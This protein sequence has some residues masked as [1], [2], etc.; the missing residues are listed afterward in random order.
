MDNFKIKSYSKKELALLFFP[1]ST[2][3]TAVNHLMGIIRRCDPLWD[4]LLAM[5]YNTNRKT[6]TPLEVAAIVEWIGAP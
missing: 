3:R 4:K 1:G 2:P 6:F 5:G